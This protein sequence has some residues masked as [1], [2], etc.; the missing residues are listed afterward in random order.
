VSELSSSGAAIPPSDE[1]LDFILQEADRDLAGNIAARTN[2]DDGY[3]KIQNIAN[4]DISQFT[5]SDEELDRELGLANNDLTACIEARV[6]VR[7]GSVRVTAK[8][9]PLASAS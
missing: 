6:D 5:M 7:R 8:H 3:S 1:G 9:G 4:D 2:L